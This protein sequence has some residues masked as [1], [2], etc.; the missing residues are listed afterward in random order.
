MMKRS[1]QNG[2]HDGDVLS[3]GN[4]SR[5]QD[6]KDAPECVCKGEQHPDMRQAHRVSDQHGRRS[7]QPARRLRECGSQASG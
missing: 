7:P 3:S 5:K 6:A 1:S 2:D 4:Q